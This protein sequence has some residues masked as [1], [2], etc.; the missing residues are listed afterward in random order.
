MVESYLHFSVVHPDQVIVGHCGDSLLSWNKFPPDFPKSGSCSLF[1]SFGGSG[2]RREFFGD[3][4]EFSSFVSMSIANNYCLRADDF[5]ISNYLLNRGVSG[6][7]TSGLLA[8]VQQLKIG[9]QSDA[10]HKLEPS[11]RYA[12]KLVYNTCGNYLRQFNVTTFVVSTTDVIFCESY[13]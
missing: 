9:L 7:D 5:L 12:H 4:A 2:F 13:C 10:L 3:S 11:V 8:P 6:F 1:E